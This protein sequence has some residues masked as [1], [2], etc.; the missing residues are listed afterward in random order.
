MIFTEYA[1]R[2]T[3]LLSSDNEDELDFSPPQYPR[4]WGAYVIK[5]GGRI[6]PNCQCYRIHEYAANATISGGYFISDSSIA[7]NLYIRDFYSLIDSIN[8]E[9]AFYELVDGCEY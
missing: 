6:S 4:E 1:A 3:E 8:E 2:I 7:K 5:E 9:L